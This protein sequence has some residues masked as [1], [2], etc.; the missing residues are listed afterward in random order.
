MKKIIFALL[1][2]GAL[3]FSGCEND[4][5]AKIYGSLSTTNYPSS[6]A[7]YENYMMDCYIPF[8]IN[9]GYTFSSWQEGFYVAEGGTIRMFDSTSDL[10]APWTISTCNIA[11]RKPQAG[12]ND[13]IFIYASLQDKQGFTVTNTK[14]PV[15][16][17]VEGDAQIIGNN[18]PITEAGI[19]PILLRLGNKKEIIKI[20]AFSD[21]LQSAELLIKP[22]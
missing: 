6:K 17:V 2:S 12:C 7:D 22:E 1:A 21:K 16:F 4:F 8:C 13:V 5:D 18:Q 19:A 3:L 9:W 14:I 20:K 15:S 11:G 10:C